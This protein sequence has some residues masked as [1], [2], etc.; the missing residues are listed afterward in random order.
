MEE[1]GE[2]VQGLP[3]RVVEVPDDRHLT[4]IDEERAEEV[5]GRLHDVRHAGGG[6]RLA[7]QSADD[8]GRPVEATIDVLGRQSQGRET[9]GRGNG[10]TGQRACLVDRADRRQV[11]HHVCPTTEGRRGETPTHDL[12]E[13]HEVG[14]PT[15][16]GTV[17]PPVAGPAD[18]EPGHHLVADEQGAVVPAQAGKACVEPFDRGDRAH[19][20]GRGLGDD[21]RD[22]VAV[23]RERLLDGGQVVVGQDEGRCGGRG[24]NPRGPRDAE[25]GETGAG[26]G[27]QG[28]DVAVVAPGELH[29]QVASGEAAGQPD[30]RHRRLGAGGH[31]A[32]L[33]DRRA[34]HDLLAELDLR[35]GR[36]AERRTARDRLGHGFDDRWMGVPQDQRS[37][38]GH[39]VD[40]LVAVGVIQ[41]GA[42]AAGHEARGATDSPE[43]AHGAVDPAGRHQAGPGEELSRARNVHGSRRIARVAV[44]KLGAGGSHRPIVAERSTRHEPGPVAGGH[45]PVCPDTFEGGD[46]APPWP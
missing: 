24:R 41:V 8:R 6:Q 2:A 28:V 35:Q 32:H 37:P 21:T 46:A 42:G 40:V 25:R 4:W 45:V 13:R 7:R 23:C 1:R 10:V 38:R 15:F 30:G 17:E 18:P 22:L 26:R 27:Q 36:R 16:D 44:T 12:A 29:D 11:R 19:V 9:G 39:Q 43:G 5:P 33:I 14:L 34:G 20:A 3:V 31:Q